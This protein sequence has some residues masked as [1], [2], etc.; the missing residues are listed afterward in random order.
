MRNLNLVLRI[1]I[2]LAVAA[3]LVVVVLDLTGVM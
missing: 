3:F 2:R 1:L